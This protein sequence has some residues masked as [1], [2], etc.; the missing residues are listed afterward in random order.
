MVR[1]E[2]AVKRFGD[3]LVLNNVS[4]TVERGQVVVIIGPS[5]SGK[6]TLLRCINHLEKIDGGRIYVDGQLVGYRL[7]KG[8]LV[9]AKEAEIAKMRAQIGFVFQRFNLFAHM[10]AL[11]NI[12]EAPIH[13]LGMPRDEAVAYAMELLRKVGLEEKAHVY[14][15]KLSGGQQQRVAIARALAMRPKLMLF[16][17]AT[18]ALDPELVGEVLKVMRQLAEEGMTMVVV[19]HEMG[20]ARDV[21]DHVIFMDHGVIV[22]EGTPDQIFDDPQSERTRNFLGLIAAD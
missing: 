15:H 21:A 3:L 2:E 17:E 5:G 4:M 6:T 22:E 18:S 7:V 16:D 12:I 10:T 8:R 13:V 20:F 14:P 9:E 11:E 19:T 1:V